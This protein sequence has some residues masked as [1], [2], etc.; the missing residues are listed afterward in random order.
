M[1]KAKKGNPSHMLG[2]HLSKE[3]KRKISKTSKRNWQN[4]EFAEKHLKILYANWNIS[5]N[6]PERRLRN[7]LNKMFPGEYRYVGD[8]K[9]W[10]GSKNPDFINVNGQ[11]KIIEMF[12]DFWHGE[13]FRQFTFNDNSSNKEHKQQRINHFARYGFRTLIVWEKE[14][15]NI[16]RLKRKLTKFHTL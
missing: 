7:G 3:H 9:V 10:I 15:K 2:K 13:K 5:P 16:P 4:P 11:K 6:K 1:S 8:G 14:L 12:G